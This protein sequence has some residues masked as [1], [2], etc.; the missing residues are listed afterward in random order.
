MN[1][2]QNELELI[3]HAQKGNM[4]AFE[5]LVQKYDRQVISIA[6][7]YVNSTEDAKDIYQEVF[8]RVYK[9]LPKFQY[10]SEFSTWLFRIATNVC[11]SYQSSKKRHSFVSLN[12]KFSDSDNQHYTLQDTLQ[13]GVKTDQ[14]AYDAEISN[15]VEQAL[16]SLSPRQKMVFTLRHYE[17][18]KI[19]E[20]AVIMN[21]KE[22]TV[23]KY[24]F[25]ATDR[26][27]KQLK[28]FE[29]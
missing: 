22:G 17:G 8:L 23:K 27:R 6:M 28:D 25:E 10:K 15:R 3:S 26:M 18:Y 5:Q 29:N 13:D 4:N 9:G 11:L 21:C 19:K 14:R 1:N 16:E 24:L 20:I 12:Q 7:K 2:F